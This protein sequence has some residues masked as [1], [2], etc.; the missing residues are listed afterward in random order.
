MK[1]C[2]AVSHKVDL[3]FHLGVDYF[4]ESTLSGHDTKY[5]PDGDNSNARDGYTYE[6]ADAGINQPKVEPRMMMGFAYNF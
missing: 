4:F 6:D 3:V 5:S 1:S 2:F